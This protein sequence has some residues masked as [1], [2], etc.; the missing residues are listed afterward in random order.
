MEVFLLRPRTLLEVGVEVTVPVLPA[1]FGAAVD[2]VAGGV[3][4]VEFLGNKPPIFFA[5]FPG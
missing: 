5:I 4:E 3:E 1:L 2:F